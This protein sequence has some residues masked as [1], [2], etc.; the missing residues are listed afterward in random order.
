MSLE[1]VFTQVLDACAMAP[2]TKGK[3]Q[4]KPEPSDEELEK[5]RADYGDAAEQRAAEKDACDADM[6]ALG[7]ERRRG[8]PGASGR[9][10]V[11]WPSWTS[12]RRVLIQF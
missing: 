9:L 8:N 2:S 10:W 1:R 7:A 5:L 12:K 4:K 11:S 3:K 6:A